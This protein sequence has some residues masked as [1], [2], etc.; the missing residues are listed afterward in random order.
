MVDSEYPEERVDYIINQ[1]SP[2]AIVV[3]DGREIEKAILFLKLT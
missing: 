1:T 3:C 2:K